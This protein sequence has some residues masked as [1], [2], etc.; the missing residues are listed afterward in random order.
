MNIFD[1]YLEKIKKILIDLSK[2]GKIILPDNLAT[3]QLGGKK[4]LNE[5][6][7]FI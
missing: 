3:P 2:E 4:S 7:T 6:I 1:N 5:L